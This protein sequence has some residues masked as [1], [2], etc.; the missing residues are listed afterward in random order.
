MHFIQNVTDYIKPASEEE[1]KRRMQ[2][3]NTCPEFKPTTQ[4]CGQCGCFMPVKT[5]MQ[6]QK[7]PIGNW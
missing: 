2:V 3:C 1:Q 5:K 7:C 4:L 6:N